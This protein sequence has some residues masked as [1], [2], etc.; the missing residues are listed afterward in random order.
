MVDGQFT[1]LEQQRPI[2]DQRD[3]FA[4][5]LLVIGLYLAG[6]AAVAQGAVLDAFTQHIAQLR[7]D[8]LQVAVVATL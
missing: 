5:D 2:N 1:F 3:P 6:I 8:S 7:L 4:H